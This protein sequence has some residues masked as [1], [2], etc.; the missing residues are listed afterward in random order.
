MVLPLHCTRWLLTI[1]SWE[2]RS[3]I[4]DWV[5]YYNNHRYYESLHN[6]TPADVYYNRVERKL[7]MRAEIKLKTIQ[8]RRKEYL[9]QKL[10][11]A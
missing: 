5:E 6:L 4:T 1:V 7:K 8:N 11:S 9:N 3:T 2:L 10:L